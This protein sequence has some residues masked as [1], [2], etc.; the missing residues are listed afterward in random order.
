MLFNASIRWYF[1][2]IFYMPN[3]TLVLIV[4]SHW[5]LKT[6]I[7]NRYYWSVSLKT[8]HFKWNYS[9]QLKGKL[10]KIHPHWQRQ[11]IANIYTE[12]KWKMQHFTQEKR[13]SIVSYYI[14][15]RTLHHENITHTH[16]WKHQ[17]KAY[18]E[19]RLKIQGERNKNTIIYYSFL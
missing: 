12:V 4:L 1:M 3:T 14:L 13:N 11:I 2:S 19:H 7:R 8:T 6:A 5:T 18:K 10:R 16:N 17:I 15:R 9:E